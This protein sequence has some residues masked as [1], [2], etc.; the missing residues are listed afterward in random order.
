[1][2]NVSEIQV[3]MET[4]RLV[5]QK[6]TEAV[7]QVLIRQLNLELESYQIDQDAPL[8]GMGLGLDSV[9]ALEVVVGLEQEFNIFLGEEA[10]SILK[11]VNSIADFLI[12][13]T[14]GT[15]A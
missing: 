6:T 2:E 3:E 5:R 4:A 15:H 14:G 12:L 11:S 13:H 9:D 10:K 7:K 1:M 8:F